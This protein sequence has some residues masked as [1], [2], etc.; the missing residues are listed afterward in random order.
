[1]LYINLAKFL[2]TLGCS[3]MR[4]YYLLL[5]FLIIS[6]YEAIANTKKEEKLVYD[7][8]IAQ[9]S[10]CMAHFRYAEKKHQIPKDLLHSISLR[11]SGRKHTKSNKMIPWPWTANVEGK[12]YYFNSKN[13]AVSFVEQQKAFGKRSIDVGCM[14]INLL[15]HPEAFKTISEGFD[16]KININ[17]GAIFLREKYDQ[18]GTW[19]KAIANYHSANE[20]RGANYHK[21]V[22]SIASN[23]EKH[24][25]GPVGGYGVMTPAK[26]LYTAA[27][28][29]QAPYYNKIQR[30]RSNMMIYVPRNAYRRVN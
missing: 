6:S 25:F 23:I 17:Y 29:K 30:Y 18:Y 7:K 22:L 14:Q 16:P 13:E 3:I 27:S 15:H 5:F 8:E 2:G 12:G 10:K 1:M 20:E 9:S 24:K 28:Y 11:E 19:K 4:S 21:S 26:P